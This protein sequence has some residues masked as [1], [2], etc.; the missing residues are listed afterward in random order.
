M[1]SRRARSLAA[2]AAI[3][4]LI[5]LPAQ[6]QVLSG[7]SSGGGGG[8]SGAVYGPTARGSSAANPPVLIGGTADGSATGAV[9]VAKVTSDGLV[10]VSIDSGGGTGGTSSSFAAAFPATG[11]AIGAKNGA[12]MVNLTAD[13]SNNLN[14]DIAAGTVAA[15]QSGTWNVTNISGTVSLP[16]GAATSANQSTEI[17][18]LGTI[19]TNSG[20]QASAAN[21]TSVIGTKGAGTAAASSLLT[22]CVYN[23]GGVTP[24]TGQQVALQCNST[25]QLIVA[26][27]GGGAITAA[28]SSYSAGAFVAGT[29]VDGWDLGVQATTAAASCASGAGLNPC[30][31]QLDADVKGP[32]PTQA[33]TVSIGG[34][35][36]LPSTSGGLTNYVLEPAAS[37]N[38]ANIKNGA[39]QVY[40]IHVFNNSATINYGRLYNAGTG[41]NGCGSATNLLYEFHIPAN[42]SDAG[43]VVPIPQGLAFSAGISVCVT[44]GY[45]QTNTTSATASAMSLNILYN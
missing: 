36:L 24:T 37:D 5:A 18:S 1:I 39:G 16:T 34:V 6:A 40:G 35:G 44:G 43:F 42:T 31:K 21:Q 23:S 29:G 41:F 3:V 32:I 9:G 7:L 15:T 11:T 8:G 2:S 25:G 13:G 26:G 14:V 20:T 28:A 33:A 4:A 45:G 19:A 38:H 17:A 27:S 22:G 10:H 30:L 12:N